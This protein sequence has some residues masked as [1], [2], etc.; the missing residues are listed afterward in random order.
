MNNLKN[1][2]SSIEFPATNNYHENDSADGFAFLGYAK[3]KLGLSS[4][5]CYEAIKKRNFSLNSE[6]TILRTR[7]PKDTKYVYTLWP[8]IEFLYE[9]GDIEII[10]DL[11]DIVDDIGRHDNGMMKYCSTEIDYIVPNVTSA[12]ALLYTYNRQIKKAIDLV[13]VLRD[14]Q[15]KGIWRYRRAN[16]KCLHPEDP[17][18]LAMM[19]HHLREIEIMGSIDTFDMVE[20]AV[21]VIEKANAKNLYAGS[22]GW[23]IPM[24]YIAI[25]DINQQL[26]QKALSMIYERYISNCNFRTKGY[27]AWA[28]TKGLIYGS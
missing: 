10:R 3:C 11:I 23:G 12:A 28:L 20:K 19:V 2:V 27:S 24:L 18:H 16:G 26:E 9:Y 8:C 13:S 17:F 22:I 7:V 5:D 15:D 1:I 6:Q 21:K 14:E 4:Q 25:K